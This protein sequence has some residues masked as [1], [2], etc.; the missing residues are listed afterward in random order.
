MT[1][2][3]SGTVITSD[4]LN[5][6]DAAMD[7][8]AGIGN[9]SD[10]TKGDALVA[11][12]LDTAGAL[13]RTQHDKNTEEVWI[14]DFTGADPTGATYSDS[15]YSAATTYLSSVG[16]GVLHFP[17]G[18][19][20]FAAAITLPTSITLKGQGYNV[21]TLKRSFT[22]D[23]ITSC[24]AL[25]QIRDL[26]INGDTATNGAGRGILYPYGSYGCIHF[27]INVYN[28]VDK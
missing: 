7:G 6:V 12:K 10:V 24:G 19:F 14:T 16:G 26:S 27:G 4:W 9:S 13:A 23:F 28:F 22:G 20:D 17:A 1:V 11:V 18:T 25:S 15:A 3:T 8:S 5:S 21:T 2:F